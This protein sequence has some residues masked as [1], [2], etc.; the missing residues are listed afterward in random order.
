MREVTTKL[1]VVPERHDLR[2]EDDP[3]RFGPGLGGVVQVVVSA[4]GGG[5][6]LVI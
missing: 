5:F 3:E 2:L 1:R 4:R 6:G